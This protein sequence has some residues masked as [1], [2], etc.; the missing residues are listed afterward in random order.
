VTEFP[1]L[2]SVQNVPPPVLAVVVPC[3]NEEEALP[4]TK[5]RL[6]RLLADLREIGEIAE[7]SAVYFIDD[8]SRDGTWEL[9]ESYA[10]VDR[11][12]GVKL[13]RNSGHQNALMAGLFTAEGDAVVSIDADLQ[14]DIAAI[15]EMVKRFRAGAEIVYGVR[16]SRNGDTWFKRRTAALFYLFMR[17]LGADSVTDHADFRL[18]SRRALQSLQ[19]YREVNLYLRGIIPLLGYRSEIVYFDRGKRIAGVSKYPLRKMIS[20]SLQGI[21]SFSIVPLRLIALLG[22]A[23]FAGSLL[24]SAW[25]LWVRLTGD[26]VPGWAS[27]VLPIYLLGGVQLFSLGVIGEYLGRIYSEVKNRPRYFI[28]RM[29]GQKP[30][31]G[32]AE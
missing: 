13:S 22:L 7:E 21:T 30:R 4:E 8:G 25:A 3:F 23:V 17:W 28:E 24:V 16:R 12:V 20:L 15:V 19:E 29:V 9:I 2:N 26:V 31:S 32:S 11:V 14:D 10:Q 6:V 18:L 5:A 27:I 1:I